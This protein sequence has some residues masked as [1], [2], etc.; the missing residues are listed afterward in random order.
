MVLT[1]EQAVRGDAVAV[2]ADA[3]VLLA[4]ALQL[5]EKEV[6]AELMQLGALLSL[7][8]VVSERVFR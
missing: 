2:E 6:V 7:V 8:L 5:V 1:L 3:A 4:A